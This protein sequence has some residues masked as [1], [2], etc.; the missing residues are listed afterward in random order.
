MMTTTATECCRRGAL[1]KISR[2]CTRHENSP[3]RLGVFERRGRVGIRGVRKTKNPAR[4]IP[5]ACLKRTRVIVFHPAP[6]SVYTR[7][8]FAEETRTMGNDVC[9]NFFI[10][11]R[12]E[13][14]VRNKFLRRG[15]DEFYYNGVRDFSSF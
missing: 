1:T 12:F 3:S 5:F 4:F 9:L 13:Y 10:R 8:V 14:A 2:F 6:A 7:R 15:G 11:V